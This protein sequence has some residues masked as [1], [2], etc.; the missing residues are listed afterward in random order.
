WVFV[1]PPY[2]QDRSVGLLERMTSLAYPLGDV[3][4]L[5]VFVRLGAGRA[6]R[7]GPFAL[8]G[9]GMLA[10]LFADSLYTVETLNGVFVAGSLLDVGWMAFYLAVGAAA[11]HPAMVAL[12]QPAPAAPSRITRGRFAIVLAVAALL[13]PMIIT[14]R[15]APLGDLPVFLGVIFVL[16]S[17][18]LARMAGLV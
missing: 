7:S 10:L 9:V 5:T 15:S 6:A 4:V 18:V 3:L 16:F 12:D 11:L 17:L 8:L 2:A 14:V 1:I 13:V